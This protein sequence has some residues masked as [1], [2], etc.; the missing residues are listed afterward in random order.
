MIKAIDTLMQNTIK[1]DY[2]ASYRGAEIKEYKGYMLRGKEPKQRERKMYITSP[3]MRVIGNTYGRLTI[4]EDLG[5]CGGQTLYGCTCICGSKVAIRSRT[6]LDGTTKSCGCL[7]LE[8]LRSR[9]GANKM[10][11]GQSNFNQLFY[12]YK[13]SA[14]ERNYPFELT[15]DEFK[16]IVESDCKY[17]GS[18]RESRYKASKGTF[19]HYFYTGCDRVDNTKGYTTENAVPCCKQCNIAKGVLGEQDFYNWISKIYNKIYGRN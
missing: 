8:L 15:K 18:H 12:G 7:N 14:R 6:I 17:C 1:K 5:I 19:G 16:K 3:S 11:L 2:T 9:A 10:E 13:K 4:I